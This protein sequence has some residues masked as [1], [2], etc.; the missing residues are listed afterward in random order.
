MCV[1][2]YCDWFPPFIHSRAQPWKF[3]KGESFGGGGQSL[4]YLPLCADFLLIGWWWGNRAELQ[5]S[6]VQ[7][8]VTI[9]H[10]VG[11]LSSCRSTQRYCFVFPWGGRGPCFNFLIDPSLFLHS[12]PSLISNSLNLPFGTPGGSRRLNEAYFLQTR[13]RGHRKNLSLG[14]RH[15]VLLHFIGMHM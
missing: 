11:G 5:G 4:P 2:Q 15:R 1:K 6:C 13:N 7:P 12:F 10:L 3:L 9:L 8:E 14:G